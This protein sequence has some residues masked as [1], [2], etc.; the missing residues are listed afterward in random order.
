MW[1]GSV[2][3]DADVAA[4]VVVAVVGIRYTVPALF[5]DQCETGKMAVDVQ[6][7]RGGAFRSKTLWMSLSSHW[8]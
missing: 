4:V 3:A 2:P 5:R 7:W 6:R 1:V 8:R